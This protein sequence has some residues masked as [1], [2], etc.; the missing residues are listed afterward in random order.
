MVSAFDYMDVL[1]RIKIERYLIRQPISIIVSITN[2]PE[3]INLYQRHLIF[4][5]GQFHEDNIGNKKAQ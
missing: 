5:N 2:N 4:K 1:T 3:I